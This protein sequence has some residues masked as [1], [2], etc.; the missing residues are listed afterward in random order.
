MT[1]EA[2]QYHLKGIEEACKVLAE[3]NP[4]FHLHGVPE[5][6]IPT[7]F[8]RERFWGEETKEYITCYF[9]EDGAKPGVQLPR[10]TIFPIKDA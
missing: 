2:F 8:R 9:L 3:Y 5:G 7:Y 10:I 1:K 6:W 4:A